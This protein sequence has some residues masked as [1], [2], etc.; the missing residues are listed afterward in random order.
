MDIAKFI[1]MILIF[2]TCFN[3]NEVCR[4]SSSFLILGGVI[5]L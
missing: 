1:R 2:T 4:F 5:V 3:F